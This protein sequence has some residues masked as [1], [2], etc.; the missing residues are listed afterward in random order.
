MLPYTEVDDS[1]F[2]LI[3]AINIRSLGS[4]VGIDS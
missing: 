4:L 1:V 3:K 2:G